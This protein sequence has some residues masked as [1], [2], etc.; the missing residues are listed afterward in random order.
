[1]KK[2]M[3]VGFALFA[4]A[5]AKAEM[6][7][8][9][10]CASDTQT[11]IG[12][13]ML[14][15]QEFIG[16]GSAALSGKGKLSDVRQK[17]VDGW[18]KLPSAKRASTLD[19]VKSDKGSREV[20]AHLKHAFGLPSS[21]SFDYAL[22]FTKE[23]LPPY[24]DENGTRNV[25]GKEPFK[26][27]SYKI[28]S[29]EFKNSN[30]REDRVGHPASAFLRRASDQ[31]VE[32]MLTTKLTDIDI[33]YDAKGGDRAKAKAM[34][35]SCPEGSKFDIL[36]YEIEV[37]QT[38]ELTG[39]GKSPAPRTQYCLRSRANCVGHGAFVDVEC[40][41]DAQSFAKAFLVPDECKD[42]SSRQ[43]ASATRLKAV[44]SPPSLG[45]ERSKGDHK[46]SQD[47]H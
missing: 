35:V 31:N 24:D 47:A 13:L 45:S 4:A 42:R 19:A 32:L 18:E 20:F 28:S 6:D 25:P 30:S 34:H 46:K 22:H 8:G 10:Y 26:R 27:D 23:G 33:R 38:V 11:A 16:D 5:F 37:R 15:A 21:A 12:R 43:A 2:L 39:S 14:A 29:F 1:M 7:H 40:K 3:T 9:M 17:L 36:I 41:P 44:G